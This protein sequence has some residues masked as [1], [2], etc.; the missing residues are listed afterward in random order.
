M[1]ESVN[2]KPP[3]KYK[4]A[5]WKVLIPMS[6]F[7]F[8]GIFLIVNFLGNIIVELVKTT[9]S[10][11]L[12]PKPFHIG[13]EDLYTFQHPLLLYLVIFLI[14]SICT[15]QFT[16]KIRSSFKDL[17]QN[18]KD[19]SRFA[20]LD[21]VKRQYRAIPEKTERYEGKGGVVISRYDEISLKSILQQAKKVM[22]AKGM[23]K[24]QEIKKLKDS[25]KAGRLL[26][27]D[28]AVSN[29]IIGTTRSGKGETFV[30]PTIDAYSRAEI[31]PSII[32]NDP[33][34]ELLAASKKTLEQRGFH[35]E[36]LNLINPLES[37]SYNLLQLIKD[38][39][40]QGDTATAQTL[41]N[42]LSYSLYYNP[43]VKD[44]FWNNSSMSLCN[45]LIL[46]IIDKCIDEKTEDKI[47]MYTVANMLSELGSKEIVIDNQGNT[48]NVLDIYFEMLPAD[49]VAKMQ[50]A[51]SNFAK[52]G[53]TRGGIFSTTMSKLSIFTFE[54]IAKMTSRN[55]IDLK[56]IGFGKS[57]QG[58]GTPRVRVQI[59]FPDGSKESIKT[60]TEGRFE[61]NF[62]QKVKKGQ[63]IHVMERETK[64]KM[65]VEVQTI[66]KD[67]GKT[68]YKVIEKQD[69]LQI[70]NL[71]IF[72]KPIAVFMIVP[73]YDSS[74][75]VI[76]SIFIRQLY[77][78][79]SKYAG[80]ARGGKCHREVVFLL[81]EFG[82][83]PPIDDM[84]NI[85][86]VCLGRNI[87]FNLI[88]QALPQLKMKYGD[89]S[90]TI[91]DNCGNQIYIQSGNKETAKEI[92]EKLGNQ[93]INSLSRSGKG[94]SIDKS[95]T[96]GI[97]TKPLLTPTEL[98]RFQEGESAVIR[99]MKRR[100]N[101]FEKIEPFPILN[102]GKTV[103]KYRWEYLGDDFDTDQSILDIDIRSLHEYVNPR[104]LI[105]DFFPKQEEEA[106]G[107]PEEPKQIV[108]GSEPEP[109]PTPSEEEPEEPQF[110]DIDEEIEIPEE[111][112]SSEPVVIVE[113]SSVFEPLTLENWEQKTAEEFFETHRSIWSVIE[114]KCMKQWNRPLADIQASTMESFI[115][116]LKILVTTGQIDKN[117]YRLI[118]GKYGEI[119]D[120]LLEKEGVKEEV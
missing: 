19:S 85:V 95:K 43:N 1:S 69:G 105:I 57:I 49:S 62:K 16:Y 39:Y 116:D 88:V 100:D 36:V 83:M 78:V 81:D 34:G 112:Y 32:A 29:L 110:A 91:Q 30:F 90:T 73:D 22:D 109:V 5:E 17:N 84:G 99:F 94:L 97:D 52:G 55:S 67:T 20:T 4:L 76:A 89:A 82:N 3:L 75:H 119:M 44:P 26:I 28:G 113:S 66:N 11:L 25:A 54:G 35:I 120:G 10:D 59:I 65:I 107:Q 106:T 111:A 13:I 12:H 8:G 68:T 18:Q 70:E 63:R 2:P 102:R 9:F 37:M 101:K 79:L 47:C 53:T 31:Q 60:D 33:K 104:D 45:A 50:Y 87:R 58:K 23:E 72:E 21:E 15:M 27:D 46:A 108:P 61:L 51:T 114:K 77:F 6:A 42:T 24:W 93:T 64:K 14:A 38:A 74:N 71:V 98:M 92:S 56:R 96:E 7:L 80:L 41:C 118:N 115:D 48:K 40:K 86:T 103:M 117:T